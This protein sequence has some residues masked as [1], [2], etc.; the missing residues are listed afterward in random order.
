EETGVILKRFTLVARPR[1]GLGVKA[2]VR[3]KLKC[4]DTESLCRFEAMMQDIEEVVECYSVAGDEDY[5]L[6]VVA[7][8]LWEY[9]DILRNQIARLPEVNTVAS[10]I[11][12]KEIKYTTKLPLP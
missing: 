5:M 8:D 6:Q 3:I 7:F 12:L 1:L 10:F 2:F 11:T 9:E 4:H